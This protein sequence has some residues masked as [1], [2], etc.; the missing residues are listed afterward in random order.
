LFV[1]QV[2]S[3]PQAESA[4]REQAMQWSVQADAAAC[5][6]LEGALTDPSSDIRIRAAT[7]LYAKCNR[8]QTG[9]RAAGQ[10]CRSA[11]LGT[12][13]AAVY[14]LLGYASRAEAEPCLRKPRPNWNMVKL[15]TST[16]PVAA[17]LAA[18]VGLA[19]LGDPAAVAELRSAFG[20]NTVDEALFLLAALPDI[21]DREALEGAIRLLDDARETPGVKSGSKRQVRDAAADALVQR[22]QIKPGYPLAANG[23][24]YSESEISA[25]REP[26]RG[27]LN[28]K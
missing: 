10:L 5:L 24:R 15:A 11:D 19:R 9:G 7:A 22:F 26:A 28:R 2:T 21:E 3:P 4:R 6:G 25:V 1:A 27:I 20:K 13:S 16:R 14:L 17:A 23:K 18:R 8:A 12:S